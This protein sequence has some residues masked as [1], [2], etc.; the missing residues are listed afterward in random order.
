VLVPPKNSTALAVAIEELLKDEPR[1]S[2]LGR[3]GQLAVHQ[4]FN[5]DAMA[6]STWEVVSQLIS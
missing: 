5:A 3:A 4:N 2:Q 1:R 6:A